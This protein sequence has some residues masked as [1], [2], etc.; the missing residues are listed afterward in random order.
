[1][2]MAGGQAPIIGRLCAS[3]DSGGS[4]VPPPAGPLGWLPSFTGSREQSAGCSGADKPARIERLT[5]DHTQ[6]CPFGSREVVRI[7]HVN[8]DFLITDAAKCNRDPQ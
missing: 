7:E 1:M 3:P 5:A 8:V 6:K 2:K 4:G